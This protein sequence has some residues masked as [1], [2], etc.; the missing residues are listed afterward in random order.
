[1]TYVSIEKSISPQI[2]ISYSRAYEKIAS[3]TANLLKANSYS[4]WFDRGSISLGD[5]WMN[6]IKSGIE[7]SSEFLIIVSREA[8]ESKIVEQEL[9]IATHSGIPIFPV[10][11]S[12]CVSS[13]PE[14]LKQLQYLEIDIGE[15]SNL[16][17]LTLRLN[18]K[19]RI[20]SDPKLLVSRTIYPR[21]NY[22]DGKDNSESD[23]SLHSSFER[24]IQKAPDS[25]AIVLN[26]G[27][28][29][30]RNDKWEESLDSLKRYAIAADNFAGW[31]FYALHLF[32]RKNLLFVVPKI[33]DEIR[34]A[35]KR[36]MTKGNSPLAKL[37]LELVKIG[38]YNHSS[39]KS[40]SI[41]TNFELECNVFEEE[42]TEFLRFYWC[43]KAS[44][45][46]LGN[47][48]DRITNVIRERQ[49]ER[50]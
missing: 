31:Y 27:L 17:N 49:N 47:Y 21:F 16:E 3:Q 40:E 46:L 37:L 29:D 8:I 28:L 24:W 41:A 23:S 38:G 22:M 9:D 36:A 20:S 33:I 18:L 45:P 14:K 19:S 7:Q 2:F 48:Q 6:E 39:R 1:M 42:R 13:L 10:V 12:D 43:I 26:K 25:S 35:L 34:D 11:M 32:R 44:L 5:D 15:I 50:K 30:A 4:I